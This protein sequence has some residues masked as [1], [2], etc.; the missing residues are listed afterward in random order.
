MAYALAYFTVLMVF[1]A[2]DAVW[3]STMGAP[4]YRRTL[5][6]ILLPTMNAVP[7]VTFYLVYA[8]G[9][10]I[11]AVAPALRSA[12]VQPALIYGALF[13]AMAYATYDLTNYATLRNWT[14]QITLFDI[15]WGAFASMV[16]AALA[17]LLSQWAI[18]WFSGS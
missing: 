2:L 11:F 10:V 4:L 17:Y 1:G 18:G 7:A 3:L 6:D 9:L 5:G 16:A 15:C 8:L 13:G 14:L 12:S